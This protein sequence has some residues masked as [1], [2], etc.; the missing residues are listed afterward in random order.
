MEMPG[1]SGSS[2]RNA[3]IVSGLFWFPAWARHLFRVGY[4]E[5]ESHRDFKNILETG[6]ALP[7]ALVAYDDT[8]AVGALRA[9]IEGGFSVPERISLIGFNDRPIC[10]MPLPKLSSVAVPKRRFGSLVVDL[11]TERI[12]NPREGVSD[13]RKIEVGVQLIRRGSSYAADKSDTSAAPA[14]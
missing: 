13:Y 7:T 12:A 10:R 9:L 4:T 14:G 2:Q 1:G 8:M 11:L 6:T 3:A 5:E